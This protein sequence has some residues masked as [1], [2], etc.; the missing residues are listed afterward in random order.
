[1]KK[2][3]LC[4]FAVLALAGCSDDRTGEDGGTNG[5]RLYEEHVQIDGR[6]ITCVVYD[7][8]TYKQGGV[9]CDFKE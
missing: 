7:D 6:D 5:H 8:Q 9:S 4:I 1:M 2:I 3:A